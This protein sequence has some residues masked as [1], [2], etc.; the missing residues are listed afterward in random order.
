MSTTVQPDASW[1]EIDPE[2]YRHGGN[3]F[4]EPELLALAEVEGE[5]VLVSPAAGGEE[6]L[7]L[8]NLGATVSVFDSKEG[9]ARAK[10]LIDQ[11]RLSVA[12]IEGAPGSPDIPGGPYD[13]VYSSFGL[14]S[15]LEYFDDWAQGIAGA[16]KPGGRLVIHDVHPAAYVPAIHKGLF[17]VAHS[18]FDEEQGATGSPFTMGDLISALGLAGL[19]TIHLEETPDS[20]RYQTPLDRHHNVRWHIRYRLPGAFVLVAFKAG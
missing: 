14:L 12:F 8:A 19:A 3:C 5:R 13:T 4:S 20:E 18:Y 6:A 17:A 11:C 1:Y 9:F 16:L 7:S 10:A 2:F 15:A